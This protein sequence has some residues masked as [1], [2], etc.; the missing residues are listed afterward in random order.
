MHK[1][2]ANSDTLDINQLLDYNL[3]MTSIEDSKSI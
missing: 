1:D 2:I 3:K